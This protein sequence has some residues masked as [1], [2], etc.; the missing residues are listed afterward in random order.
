[1]KKTTS[2]IICVII[3]AMGISCIASVS[4][5]ALNL[6]SVSCLPGDVVEIPLTISGN[7]GIAGAVIKISYDSNLELVD[8]AQGDAFG[9]LTYT[10]PAKMTSNPI[11]LLWDGMKADLSNGTLV[12]L[13][14]KAPVN[15]G[16]YSVSAS[17]DIGGIYDGNM[18]DIDVAIKNGS[19]A[20]TDNGTVKCYMNVGV[21]DTVNIELTGS[22]ECG[23]SV[24]VALYDEGDT[25]LEIESYP[26]SSSVKHKFRDMSAGKYIKVFWWND[27]N[28]TPYVVNKTLYIESLK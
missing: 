9:S 27:D 8:I 24:F 7:T 2:L 13:K 6:G 5:T 19:I 17:Y 18:N 26:A 23:G 1:M 10:P 16:T 14:F 12:T 15:C 28:L 22:Q 11:T 3:F 25:M 20:V 4:E 21:S